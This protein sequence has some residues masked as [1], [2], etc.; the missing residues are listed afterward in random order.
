VSTLQRI[1]RGHEPGETVTVE[2]MRYGTKKTFRV[3]LAEAPS[4]TSV[5]AR[6]SEDDSVAP[7]SGISYDKIGVRLEPISPAFA[8]A[9]KI[10]EANRGVRVVDV[11]AS[12]PARNRLF[13][14]DIITAVLFPAPRK[15][16]RNVDDLQGVLS[17]AKD[18]DYISLLIFDAQRNTTR[19]ANIRVGSN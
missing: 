3:K 4:E 17:R 13:Q 7:V 12:G 19:V 9:N 10:P 14:N 1:I 8:Q 15:E 16:V 18:G 11:N 5:A 2:V 6:E